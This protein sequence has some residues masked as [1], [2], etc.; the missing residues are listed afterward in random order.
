NGTYKFT[1]H[2]SPDRRLRNPMGMT[3]P[4]DP[5][6]EKFCWRCHSLTTNYK[7]GGGPAKTTANRDYYNAADMSEG[8]QNMFNLLGRQPAPD[9]YLLSSG[10][11]AGDTTFAR[12]RM[13]TTAGSDQTNRAQYTVTGSNYYRMAQFVSPPI[14][15]GFTWASG[16]SFTLNV[17]Y[18]EGN[19]S[20]NAFV[21]YALYQW[22]ESDAAGTN[23]RSVAQYGTEV[24]ASAGNAAIAFTSSSAVTF[25][26]GDRIALEIEFYTNAATLSGILSLYWGDATSNARLV[27]PDSQ[28]FNDDGTTSSAGTLYLRGGSS[29]PADSFVGIHKPQNAEGLASGDGSLS[30]ANRHVQC[31]DCHNPHAASISGD[32]GTATSAAATSLTDSTKDGKWL[33]DQWAGYKVVITSGTAAGQAQS[34]TGNTTT[35]Q[36]NVAAWSNPP[37]Q[38]PNGSAYKVTMQGNN[39]VSGATEGV[40]GVTVTPGTNYSVGSA[41]FIDG[42]TTVYS[43]ASGGIVTT[44]S[45]GTT[46]T[47]ATRNWVTDQWNTYT[48]RVLTGA[49]AGQTRTISAN[50]QTTLT[51][52]SAVTLAQGDVFNIYKSGAA[53]SPVWTGLTGN[54]RNE[55]DR[56][57]RWYRIT[58]PCAAGLD[59]NYFTC[60]ITPAYDS[61]DAGGATTLSSTRMTGNTTA[62]VMQWQMDHGALYQ[63]SAVSLAATAAATKEYEICLKC[64][65]SWA[66]GD[67]PPNVPSGHQDGTPLAETNVALD[68]NSNQLGYHPVFAAGKNQPTAVTYAA[69][70]SNAAFTRVDNT[71]NSANFGLSNTFTTGWFKESLM[72]CTDCHAS[73]SASDPL[74]PHAS[75]KRWMLKGLDTTVSWV[76]RNSAGT[77]WETF[78][79]NCVGDTTPPCDDTSKVAAEARNY[80]LNCHRWDVYGFKTLSGN[81]PASAL[82]RVPHDVTGNS[83]SYKSPYPRSDIVCNQC[84]GGDRIGGIHGSSRRKY[85]YMYDPSTTIS[86]TFSTVPASYS[87][88]RLLNGAY[89]FGVTRAT[90]GTGVSCWG[91]A[92]TDTVSLCAKTHSGTTSSVAANY[93]YDDAADP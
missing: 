79:N 93:S 47:S 22:S 36:L 6:E 35:G 45:T 11:Y 76:R 83:N 61:Y 34:I 3:S 40:R 72:Q 17:R 81:A 48:F 70:N 90:T 13:R 57:G 74:G 1:L 82:S 62:P 44:A 5:L 27:L 16:S 19:T 60:T 55:L 75:G 53:D 26:A 4:T 39:A 15:T 12:Y 66:Y 89:W 80:C 7:P 88:K 25:A 31:E 38:P 46:V 28:S 69:W 23:F 42:S 78:T 29:H 54:I 71:G 41:T 43:G 64:H 14:T 33:T 77:G 2:A 85:P 37:G 52:N 21:R 59:A 84:H 18:S 8:S 73:D 67:T 86:A 51:L 24:P 92:G 87:G 56:N 20:V 30:G 10:T 49:S 9:A 65:S 68:Y 50:A 58:A 91:K 63:I 32:T